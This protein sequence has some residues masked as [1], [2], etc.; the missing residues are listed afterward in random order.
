MQ[1]NNLK[2]KAIQI[3]KQ[4]LHTIYTAK[5]GHLGGTMSMVDVLV[6]LFYDKMNYDPQNPKLPSRDRFVLSKGHSVESYYQVLADV[7]FFPAE[8]LEHYC[9]YGSRLIG[10]P[11]CKV[12]GV[13]L[14][15]GA[16][17]HGLSA[18]V[19]MALGSR[20]D[21][22]ENFIYVM[23]GDGEQAEGSVWEA[24]MAAANYK[25]DHLVAI[26]DRNMLQISG[27]TEEVMALE[28]LA[29]KWRSFGWHVEEMDGN[30]MAAVQATL[31]KLP[32]E[33]NKPSLILAHTVKAK[34]ICFAENIAKWHHGVPNAE[35][36]QQAMEHLALEE[37][38]L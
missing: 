28:N 24:A 26:V 14:C 29:D 6:A 21:G 16:L 22:Y 38:G 13:E 27:C 36:Y 37:E 5:A 33:K 4:A 25:L 3:R 31:K 35:Q 34:G 10:H 2:K 9:Q 32:F 17:G 19:G 30:N 18:G 1:E 23:M 20:M 15:T 7:G 8:E 12:P 11:N